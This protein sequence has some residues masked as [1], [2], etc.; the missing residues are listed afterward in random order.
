MPIEQL[1]LSLDLWQQT[2]QWQPTLAQQQQFQQLYAGILAGNQRLNLTRITAPVDF[3]E[4]HLWDSLNGL[5]PWLDATSASGQRVID[6]G[7]GGGF[8]GL[9]AAIVRP[10]WQVTLLDATQKKIQYLTRLCAELALDTVTCIAERAESLGHQPAHREQYDLALV[11]AVGPA[12]ACAEYALPLLQVGGIAALFRGQWSKA[13]AQ[14][15]TQAL[16]Q[17]GGNLMEIRAGKTPL[18]QAERHCIYLQK[19]T[20]TEPNFPRAVGIPAKHPL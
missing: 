8:P 4:K 13:E 14:A 11:R 2:L 7:T 15:L 19:T 18:T 10:D 5:A 17:L 9:P 16:P 20:P 3:W 6:I 12:S 1:P